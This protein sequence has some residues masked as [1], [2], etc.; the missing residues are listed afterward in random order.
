MSDIEFVDE[1]PARQK[2][3][4]FRQQLMESMREEAG[5]SPVGLWLHAED[6]EGREAAYSAVKVWRAGGYEVKLSRDTDG[7]FGYP[8]YVIQVRLP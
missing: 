8:I 5:R 2:T 4:G 6:V 1:P 3:T 7:P